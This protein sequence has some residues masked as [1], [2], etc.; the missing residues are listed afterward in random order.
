[1]IRPSPVPNADTRPYWDAAGRGELAYR[2]CRDCGKPQFP[3][4]RVCRHC[5]G[6][7]LD[8][9]ISSARGTIH[10]FTIV[11]R[12]PTPAFTAPYAILL[13]DLEEGF[14][15]MTNVRHT[16]D[17]AGLGIGLPVRIVFEPAGDGPALPQAELRP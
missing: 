3:P 8:W 12:A 1:M 9:R 16:A 10:S 17:A 2:Q 11:H 6:E 4:G 7:A 15:I 14:R 5:H 13:V